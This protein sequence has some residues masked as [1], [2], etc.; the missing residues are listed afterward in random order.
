MIEYK[1]ASCLRVNHGQLC[2]MIS[3]SRSYKKN[4]IVKDV[5][6]DEKKFA[7][8]KVRR[9]TEVPDGKQYRKV[10]PTWDVIDH[11]SYCSKQEW[12]DQWHYYES[13]GETIPYYKNKKDLEDSL[14]QWSKWY[15]RK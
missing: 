1:A 9:T 5:S 3:L 4:P 2:E 8:R 15:Y 13:M 10:Y 7:N 14:N 6:R 11:S 12:I